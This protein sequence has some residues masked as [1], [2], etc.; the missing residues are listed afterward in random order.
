MSCKK[1]VSNDLIVFDVNG[2]FP[3]KT[4]DIEDV[5]DI[6]YLILDATD[7]N[8]LFMSFVTM[9]E[10]YAIC[11]SSVENEFLFFNRTTGKPVSK[12]SRL[13]NGPG[14][15]TIPA[16][17]VYSEAKDEFFVFDYAAGIKVYGKDG[18]FKRQLPFDRYLYPSTSRAFYD[19]D[20]EHLLINCFSFKGG[21]K[22]S[23]FMLISKQDGATESIY[24]PYEEH[25]SLI[26]TQGMAG[27]SAQSN[28]AVRNGKD[29]LLTDYSSDTVYRFTPERELIPVLVR[30]PSI[31]KMEN[32]ILLHSWLETSS[33][34]FFST[35]GLGFDWDR[36]KGLPAKGYLMDKRS[37]ELFQSKVQML[38][39]KGKELII[40][41]SVITKTSS[42][43]TGVIMLSAL[44]LH[45]A[46]EENKLSGKLKEATEHLTDNDEYVFMILKF[47]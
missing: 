2:N 32:K 16:V 17:T 19:Y 7:D 3:I 36:L 27:G 24:I 37:G 4:L 8:Y 46:N 13:G 15:Y 10:N 1:H 43:H 34:L 40:G 12:V 25:V 22:D 35:D 38:D 11:Y 6:E 42:Q 23:S 18:T 29:Y 21:M 26:I 5:A 41:P 45:K 30:K 33:Y 47:K 39:Y 14:E 28:H 31:Q 44:E 20:E 9:T